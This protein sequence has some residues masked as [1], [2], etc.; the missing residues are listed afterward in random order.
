MREFGS[1]FYVNE[2]KN[3][4]ID[5]FSSFR[6]QKFL[7]TGREALGLVAD[8]ISVYRETILIPAY[9]CNSMI[10]PFLTRG[11]EIHYY[12]LNNNFS[13]K[14]PELISL[15]HK[16]SPK[17]ILLMNYFGVSKTESIASR[18]KS[19]FRD[20]I[21][22]EDF[23][24]VLFS[25]AV[26]TNKYIDYFAASIRKWIPI[27]DG[28]IFLSRNYLTI[29]EFEQNNDFLKLRREGQQGKYNYTYCKD[30]AL[31]IS[32]RNSLKKAE[33]LLDSQNFVH[34][35]S[36]ESFEILKHLNI[37][38]LAYSRRNNYFHLKSLLE[39]VDGISI[40]VKY[41]DYSDTIPFSF[42]VLLAN[43][44]LVQTKFADRG[45]YAPVLWPL[46]DSCRKVC[47]F[48]C[49]MADEMLSIPIDQRYNFDDIEDIASIIKSVLAEL[50]Y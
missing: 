41:A 44:D 25:P 7:S 37:N 27:Y 17:A 20:I 39:I 38:N 12:P 10:Q 21:L 40:P 3:D 50:T 35:I 2:P 11:W 15:C 4:F 34:S 48:S 18:I 8:S 6:T 19:E 23:T 46:N 1:E 49:R 24:H 5:L 43:R 14:E 45:L 30:D 36:E 29:P 42:P 47:Q 28:A 33:Q 31:K 32:F 16:Y 26:F 9:C 13:V 22:I